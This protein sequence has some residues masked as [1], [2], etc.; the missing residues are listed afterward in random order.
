MQK[1]QPTGMRAFTVVWVGQLVSLFGTAMSQ[2]ALTVWAYQI[3][4]EAT[5]LALVAFFS[6]TPGVL[7]S[8]I[9][10]AMVDRWNRKLVMMLS[11][12][13]AGIGTIGVF[14]LYSTGDLQIWH[15]CV[16]GAFTS[17]F[18]A[19]Q[20][21][22]YSAAISTMLKKEQYARANGMIGLAEALP[23]VFA[24]PF[25]TALLVIIGIQGVMLIDIVTFLFALG[26]LLLVYIP[27][28]AMSE[29][30]KA[31][32]GSLW[33]ESGYG[34][35]FIWQNKPLL[36]V[37]L[38]FF[39]TNLMHALTGTLRAPMI[40]ARAG[41]GEAALAGVQ[42]AAAVGGVLGGLLLSSVGAPKR[43][44]I[45]VLGG[46]LLSSLFETVLMGLGQ[47]FA[48]WAVAGFAGGLLVPLLNASNQSLW[49]AKVPPDVQGRVFAARRMI[50]QIT[51]PVG[52]AITGPLA[53]YVFEPAMREGGSLVP[54]F[55][56]LVGTGAGAGMAV[57]MVI[58]GTLGAI[59][60]IIFYL[61]PTVR[62]V[63]TLMPDHDAKLPPETADSAE[64]APVPA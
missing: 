32:K 36:G 53:D 39:V 7:V 15:L 28:P 45:G 18:G 35:R 17:V 64:S 26:M 23:A 22:A 48:V 13:G 61:I 10:G 57:M 63:E 31:S 3:T 60:P 25:A 49:Q 1:N 44:I 24:A 55:G 51:I 38:A 34:F 5:A 50:A 14:I 43:K 56:G 40:L 41:G 54:I 4:E 52:M 19:F 2:F 20:W 29:T 33:K 6:F 12:L 11:D 59:S 42:S 21:P 9:A 8:P 16:A 27:Q 62:H 37:Q 30:G 47:T 58:F 46:M